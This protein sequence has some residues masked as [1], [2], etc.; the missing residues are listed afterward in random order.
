MYIAPG[1][2]QTTLWGQMLMSTESPY[3][4][5]LSLCPF[6]A[7]FKTISLKYD[8]KHILNYMI[9]Y[10]YIAPRQGQTTLWVQ[11]FNVKRNFL[12]LCPFVASLIKIS[13]KSDFLS[14]F[15]HMYIAPGNPLGKN[16][17]WNAKEISI[18]YQW[19]F[20]EIPENY[21]TEIPE[22]FQCNSN[23]NFQYGGADNPLWTKFWC[24]QKCLVTLPICCKFQK[25]I[26]EVWFYTYFCLFLYMYIAPGQE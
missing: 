13:L 20:T 23:E 5:A 9:L 15:F 1:Q 2:G 18:K 8:F 19:N 6:F 11:N 3:H 17:L 26:F 10:M 7:S 12:S 25:N 14:F 22:K 24:Q 16:F 21:S 4:F